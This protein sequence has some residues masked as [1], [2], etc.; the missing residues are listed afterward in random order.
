VTF[1]RDITCRSS[2]LPTALADI[3]LAQY[4]AMVLDTQGS[5]LLILQSAAAI[6]GGFNYIQVEAA[7][8]EVYRNCAT[9][10]TLTTF[11][12]GYGFRLLHKRLQ[13]DARPVGETFDLLFKRKRIAFPP[14]RRIGKSRQ[15]GMPSS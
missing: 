6:L 12:S 2:R 7:N 1:T 13:R 11:L 8:F 9:V 4:D 14:L 15:S 5:E 10:D 3:D